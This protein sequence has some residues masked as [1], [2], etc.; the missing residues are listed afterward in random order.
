M[1]CRNHKNYQYLQMPYVD[2]I[3]SQRLRI[4]KKPIIKQS[5]HLLVIPRQHGGCHRAV[6][7]VLQLVPPHPRPMQV[8]L[9]V[10]GHHKHPLQ[11]L[12]ALVRKVVGQL[13]E[14]TDNELV[15][16][17]QRLPDV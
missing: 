6:R 13:L 7:E 3:S 16:Y 8:E 12:F 9:Q 17:Q 11:F 2:I 10:A 14:G 5:L 15:R 4:R 1:K